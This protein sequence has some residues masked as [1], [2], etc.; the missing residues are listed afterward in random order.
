MNPQVAHS[1]F[2]AGAECTYCRTP[3]R[4]VID[5]DAEGVLLARRCIACGKEETMHA[6]EESKP[7]AVNPD[8]LIRTRQLD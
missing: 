2:V 6:G 1:R 7:A 3:D 5:L 8:V 4:M